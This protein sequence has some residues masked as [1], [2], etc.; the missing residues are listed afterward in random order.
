MLKPYERPCKTDEIESTNEAPKIE[1]PPNICLGAIQ[2]LFNVTS[3]S[4]LYTRN[5]FVFKLE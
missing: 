4:S 3:G 5:N 2:W 1:N